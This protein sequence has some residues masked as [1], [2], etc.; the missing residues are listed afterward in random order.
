MDGYNIKQSSEI[1]INRARISR[2]STGRTT[3]AVSYEGN[4]YYK[5]VEKKTLEMHGWGAG[6]G[7]KTISV[8]SIFT[9]LEEGLGVKFSRTFK[10]GNVL[11][12]ITNQGG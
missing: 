12:V 9:W 3:G 5:N 1:P 6:G 8:E 4:G 10:K 2:L 11:L 7:E